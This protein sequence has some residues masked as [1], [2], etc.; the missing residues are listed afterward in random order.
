MERI[1]RLNLSRP[2]PITIALNFFAAFSS[3]L[4]LYTDAELLTAIFR[5]SQGCLDQTLVSEGCAQH[6]YMKLGIMLA[7]SI[8]APFIISYSHIIAN[9]HL[10]KI[11]ERQR[12]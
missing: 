7:I 2:D 9:L 6:T 3:V 11:N 10:V 12:Y 5:K 4:D 1:L 8:A